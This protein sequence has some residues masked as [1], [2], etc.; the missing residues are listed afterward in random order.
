MNARLVTGSSAILLGSMLLV[1]CGNAYLRAPVPPELASSSTRFDGNWTGELQSRYRMRMP[2]SSRMIGKALLC[3]QYRD[4][5]S[6]S[7]ENGQLSIALGDAADYRLETHLDSQGRFFQ[8]MALVSEPHR[9]RSRDVELWV[10]GQLDD[11]TG[12]AQGMIAVNPAGIT[13]GCLGDFQAARDE[14]PKPVSSL[15]EPFTTEYR[16]ITMDADKL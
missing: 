15:S 9:Y 16:F 7:L 11:S 8:S 13:Y 14:Q 10:A 6:L 1:G 12:I 3:E 2:S 4:H 5:V